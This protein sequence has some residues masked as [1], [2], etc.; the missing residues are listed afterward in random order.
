MCWPFCCKNCRDPGLNGEKRRR[1]CAHSRCCMESRKTK[2][3]YWP[4]FQAHARLLASPRRRPAAASTCTRFCC[5][6]MI[7]NEYFE[8]VLYRF[9]FSQVAGISKFCTYKT[10]HTTDTYTP[11]LNAHP[12]FTFS[13]PLSFSSQ[14]D[15]MDATTTSTTSRNIAQA[16]DELMVS[17]P[18]IN[19][20]LSSQSSISPAT[21]TSTLVGLVKK[22]CEACVRAKIKCN[23]QNPCERCHKRGINCIYLAEQKRGRRSLRNS[24]HSGTSTPSSLPSSPPPPSHQLPPHTAKHQSDSKRLYLYFDELNNAST[25]IVPVFERRMFRI[26]FSLFKFHRDEKDMA[27]FAARYGQLTQLVQLRSSTKQQSSEFTEFLLRHHLITRYPITTASTTST[28][29]TLLPSLINLPRLPRVLM[30]DPTLFYLGAI[31][32]DGNQVRCTPDITQW[33]GYSEDGRNFPHQ[34]IATATEVFPWGADVLCSIVEE[35]SQ[36]LTYLRDVAF[37]FS[38]QTP[39]QQRQFGLYNQISLMDRAMTVLVVGSN[40]MRKLKCLVSCHV[41]QNEATGKNCAMFDFYLDPNQQARLLPLPDL[42]LAPW[43][44]NDATA[45]ALPSSALVQWVSPA[46]FSPSQGVNKA[47]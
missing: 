29:S 24:P 19:A 42:E 14:L 15:K 43:P 36:V 21:A 32:V 41:R 44:V 40:T 45:N 28:K 8:G 6:R 17:P 46:P 12:L 35:D 5:L 7:N 1:V 2:I 23:G 3:V 25:S 4:T 31:V 33:L 39:A 37:A 27:W 10:P 18:V 11:T 26:V 30:H 38:E 16:Q 13:A 20:T 34:R 47:M 22:T 9:E